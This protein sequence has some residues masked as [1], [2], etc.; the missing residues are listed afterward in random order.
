VKEVKPYTATA[1]HIENASRRYFI[2]VING[3]ADA[4]LKGESKDYPLLTT[5]KTVRYI[6]VQEKIT[7]A[8]LVADTRNTIEMSV[9]SM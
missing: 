2:M 5:G 3:K 1:T 9:G 7:I 6:Y 4:P 8:V